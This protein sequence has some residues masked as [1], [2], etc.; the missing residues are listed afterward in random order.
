MIRHGYDGLYIS[1]RHRSISRLKNSRSHAAD[2][3]VALTKLLIRETSCDAK[4]VSAGNMQCM[5]EGAVHARQLVVSMRFLHMLFSLPV[6]RMGQCKACT[7]QTSHSADMTT[8]V[9]HHNE[10]LDTCKMDWQTHFIFICHERHIYTKVRTFAK[11]TQ[12]DFVA[13]RTQ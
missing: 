13:K 6:T 8:N 4:L 12:Y 7:V 11:C 1:Y 2:A 10:D 5:C 9:H 3:M